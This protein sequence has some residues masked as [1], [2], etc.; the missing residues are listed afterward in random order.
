MQLLQI[1]LKICEYW[2]NGSVE[3]NICDTNFF[4]YSTRYILWMNELIK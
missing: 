1:I 4:P 3:G 2:V